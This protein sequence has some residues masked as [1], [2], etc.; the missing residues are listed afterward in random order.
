MDQ[1]VNE[2]G[3]TEEEQAQHEAD[4]EAWC[5]QTEITKSLIRSG[6]FSVRKNWRSERAAMETLLFHEDLY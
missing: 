2:H 1:V 3:L 5:K 6:G 4:Y